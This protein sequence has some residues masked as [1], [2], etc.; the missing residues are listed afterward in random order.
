MNL[1]K[2]ISECLLITFS[3]L[4][5]FWLN[6]WNETRQ[7]KNAAKRHLEGIYEEI[8]ANITELEVILPY[9]L[10]LLQSLR[11]KPLETNVVLRPPA[12]MKEAW[13][14]AEGDVFKKHIEAKLYKRLSYVYAV[15]DYLN[16]QGKSAGLQMDHLNIFAPYYMLN[17]ANTEPSEEDRLKFRR[18]TKQSWIPIFEDWTATEEEYL[19][20][21]KEIR[22]QRK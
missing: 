10:N 7:E 16:D 11:E 15:H 3:V 14:L 17:G 9:H 18:K 4:L 5:A 12:I 21:L 2:I 20:V 13:K 22:D 1:K 6:S 19:K 8:D